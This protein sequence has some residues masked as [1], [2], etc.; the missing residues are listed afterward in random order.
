MKILIIHG[1]KSGKLGGIHKEFLV[2]LNKAI[3]LSK[4][5]KFDK[6]I[7]SGG[8]TRKNIP[9]EAG[10]G[11]EYLNNKITGQ[12]FLE[13]KSKTT[14]ENVQYTK[15]IIK[16]WG[17]PL[18]D[19]EIYVISSKTRIARLKYLYSVIFPEVYSKIKFIPA[20][21][22]YGFVY[23]LIEKIYHLIAFIDPYEKILGKW[24]KELFRNG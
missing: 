10:Q 22:S 7:I 15:T 12:I 24:K 9:S 20:D 19:F 6:I 11:F 2:R 23:Q 5:N 16:N 14:P 13:D 18:R 4:E 17:I 3:N 8:Q 21:D 1:E